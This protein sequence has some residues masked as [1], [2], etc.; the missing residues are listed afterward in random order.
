RIC[1]ATSRASICASRRSASASRSASS[2]S[3]RRSRF[4]LP[5]PV[6]PNACTATSA[7]DAPTATPT[8]TAI[9]ISTCPHLARLGN[10]H[11]AS[12]P[13]PR[14]HPERTLDSTC[15]R[16][17]H[18]QSAAPI[19]PRTSAGLGVHG[20][21]LEW[22]RNRRWFGKAQV[23]RQN[24]RWNQPI[25]ARSPLVRKL[26]E[27]LH[28]P[29]VEAAGGEPTELLRR[30]A[31]AGEEAARALGL[32]LEPREG[33]LDLLGEP[34]LLEEGPDRGVAVAASGE[35]RRTAGGDP[36]VVHEAGPL[37]R[38]EGVGTGAAR[39]PPVGK[40][41]LEPRAREVTVA[42]GPS[43]RCERVGPAKLAGE[44][45]RR[46]AV[47]RASGSEAG[48]NDGIRRDNAPRRAVELDL[49]PPARPLPQRG[50]VSDRRLPCPTPRRRPRRARPPRRRPSPPWTPGRRSRAP[51]PRPAAGASP[52]R[53][54]P[55]RPG[56][57]CRA[58][59][60]A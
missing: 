34:L 35:R 7:S 37:E 18:P 13:Q 50:D 30:P 60:P 54:A 5:T 15:A 31:R 46:G 47:Q 38:L 12:G 14:L 59:S 41:R 16:R 43:G 20:W 11:P 44:R 26:G 24:V 25:V 57:G 45:P 33:V 3:C 21:S 53:P 8:T 28:D 42:E 40:P 52:R 49:D 48:P 29:R 23:C 4:A 36:A 58:G 55:A 56:A 19:R 22:S 32:R 17:A 9:P 39:R 27:L 51:P 6:A 10:S 2:R 1:T